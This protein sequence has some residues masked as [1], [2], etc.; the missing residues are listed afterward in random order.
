MEDKE[1]GEMGEGGWSVFVS[2]SAKWGGRSWREEA[3]GESGGVPVG[4]DLD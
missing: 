4:S 1:K 3:V 2:L